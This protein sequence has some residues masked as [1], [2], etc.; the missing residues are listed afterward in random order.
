MN[1]SEPLDGE[2]GVGFVVPDGLKIVKRVKIHTENITG[3]CKNWDSNGGPYCGYCQKTGLDAQS[4]E[5]K[6]GDAKDAPACLSSHVE[7]QCEKVESKFPKEDASEVSPNQLTGVYDLPILPREVYGKV[8]SVL[9]DTGSNSLVIRL[10]PV[11]DNAMISTKAAVLLAVGSTIKLSAAKIHVSSPYF[12]GLAIVKCLRT[13]L[14]DVI[15]GNLTGSRE[16]TDP[17]PAW[18]PLNTTKLPGSRRMDCGRKHHNT[19]VV[20]AKV[21][22]EHHTTALDLLQVSRHVFPK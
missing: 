11:A 18:K 21:A 3:T 14:Y 19:V 10:S 4:C 6:S 13:P 20:G 17:D 16:P 2:Q 9:R 22:T 7:L 5:R 8:V 12:S 15:V 1:D